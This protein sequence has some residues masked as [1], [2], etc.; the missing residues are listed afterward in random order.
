MSLSYTR[1]R[2]GESSLCI[3]SLCSHAHSPDRTQVSVSISCSRNKAEHSWWQKEQEPH[4]EP[5]LSLDSTGEVLWSVGR[6]ASQT[7]E[8]LTCCISPALTRPANM[9]F[10]SPASSV[11]SCPYFRDW[12]RTGSAN[13]YAAAR[14][15]VG[16]HSRPCSGP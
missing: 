13:T 3:C 2:H 12:Y 11:L 15:S 7:G 9:L 8:E 1:L 6:Y 14:L 4:G 16:N 10:L 5:D